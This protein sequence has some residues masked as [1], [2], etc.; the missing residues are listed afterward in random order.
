MSLVH[1]G[2]TASSGS[3]PAEGVD[4]DGTYDYLSRSTDLVGNVDSKTFTFSAWVY[5]LG[6]ANLAPYISHTGSTQAFY[7]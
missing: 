1:L 7:T 3:V 5:Y 4:F 6:G 2:S